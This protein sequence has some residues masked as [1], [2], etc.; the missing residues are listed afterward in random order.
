MRTQDSSDPDRIPAVLREFGLPSLSAQQTAAFEAYLEILLKWNSRTNLTAIRDP[1]TIVRRHFVECI[2]CARLLPEEISSLLD[3]GSGAGFP[4]IPIAICMPS[5]SVTL[6][7]S[8]KKKA[9]FLHEAA[10]ILQLRV[11]IF[12]ARAE[13]ISARFD[14]V[15][16]R[17]VDQMNVA[18]QLASSMLNPGGWLA[19][20]TTQDHRE[21]IANAAGAEFCWKA[22]Q[23]PASEQQL[24]LLGRRKLKGNVPRG[25]L[26]A[27]IF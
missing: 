11:A 6:A 4:G 5:L 25:T 17:A 16:L 23:L 2:A 3:F 24:L 8:Q 19:V 10:R 20:M 22:S 26:K 7:E 1:E 18:I 12:G 14:C 27:R 13:L 9:A 21:E 15:I